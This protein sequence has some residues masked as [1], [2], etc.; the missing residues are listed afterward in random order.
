MSEVTG[1]RPA[2]S[3]VKAM[4]TEPASPFMPIPPMYRMLALAA[5]AGTVLIIAI[6]ALHNQTVGAEIV[7]PA[8]CVFAVVQAGPLIWYRPSFGWV[9][10]VADEFHH[11]ADQQV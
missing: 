1:N 3:A 7:I 11:G 8:L 6:V 5:F 4:S 9:R 2:I 10:W